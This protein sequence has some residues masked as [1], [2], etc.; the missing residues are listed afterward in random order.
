MEEKKIG[1]SREQKYGEQMNDSNYVN[2]KFS[3]VRIEQNKTKQNTK[4]RRC[5]FISWAFVTS[6][7]RTCLPNHFQLIYCS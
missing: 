2:G 3:F 4:N 7:V 1:L 5:T 6:N